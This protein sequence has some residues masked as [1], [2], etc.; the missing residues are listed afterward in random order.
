MLE[1]D[2][3]QSSVWL[4]HLSYSSIQSPVPHAALLP[5]LIY[6]LSSPRAPGKHLRLLYRALLGAA[7]LMAALSSAVSSSSLYGMGLNPQGVQTPSECP[8]SHLAGRAGSWGAWQAEVSSCILEQFF[9]H[10]RMVPRPR[11]GSPLPKSGG[12]SKQ[13]RKEG[14]K[15]QLEKKKKSKS[16]VASK[17]ALEGSDRLWQR[18]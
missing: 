3:L 6:P 11:P 2:S 13:L 4:P 8:Y 14:A 10:L 15:Y 16:V 5:E 7:D 1:V 12:V 9:F 17:R 18:I